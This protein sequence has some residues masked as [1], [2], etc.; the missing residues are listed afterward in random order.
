MEILTAVSHRKGVYASQKVFE[1]F[2]K[3]NIDKRYL[4]YVLINTLECCKVI[5][6]FDYA[7]FY[8]EYSDFKSIRKSCMTFDYILVN[9]LESL[10]DT[11]YSEILKKFLKMMEEV[12][13]GKNENEKTVDLTSCKDLFK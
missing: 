7:D 3:H 4:S 5:N 10:N 11:E 6:G 8:N 2:E 13:K 1:L 12:Y 9:R